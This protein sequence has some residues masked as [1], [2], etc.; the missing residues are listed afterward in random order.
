MHEAHEMIAL[1]F[2]GFH[3]MLF[4]CIARRIEQKNEC[5]LPISAKCGVLVRFCR[6]ALVSDVAAA[7]NVSDTYTDASITDNLIVK[8]LRRRAQLPLHTMQYCLF[9]FV[10]VGASVLHCAINK[11]K[12]LKVGWRVPHVRHRCY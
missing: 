12:L 4:C 1:S 9:D 8:L 2:L 10:V 5:T 7:T 6:I 11:R 3:P